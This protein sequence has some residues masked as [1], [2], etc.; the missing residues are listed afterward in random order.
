MSQDKRSILASL[1]DELQCWEA[2]LAG[3]SDA[4]IMMPQPHTAWSVKD[5]IAHLWAWQQVSIA[6][7]EAALHGGEPVLPDWLNGEDP[8][9]EE[10]LEQ[11]NARI[12]QRNR[13]RAWPDVYG[14]WHSGFLKFVELGA[15]LPEA[16]LFDAA[17]YPWLKG[18]APADVLLGSL[19]H[20]REHREA[21]SIMRD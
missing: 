19:E 20:H 7:M 2:L 11:F 4:Q 16:T 3:L 13:D 6:R 15:A 12:Y 5:V 10:H 9:S 14:A 21:L 17:R 1:R 18:Y 8:E